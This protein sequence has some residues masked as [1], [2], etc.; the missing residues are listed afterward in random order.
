MPTT[1]VKTIMLARENVEVKRKNG[2]LFDRNTDMEAKFVEA[3]AAGTTMRIQHE[4]AER[5]T[6]T[7]NT[8]L[9]GAELSLE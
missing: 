3:L 4:A 2:T 8:P 5:H 6:K 7:L 1:I 9:A